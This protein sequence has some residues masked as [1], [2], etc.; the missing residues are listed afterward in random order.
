MTNTTELKKLAEAASLTGAQLVGMSA[1][2]F[3]EAQRL[4]Q[5]FRQIRPE[6]ILKLLAINADLV[7]EIKNAKGMI[8]AMKEVIDKDDARWKFL[9]TTHQDDQGFEWCVMRVKWDNGQI[10]EALHTYANLSD[11]DA[12]IARQAALAKAE[13][14]E[15]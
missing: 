1:P 11:M 14:G 6:A 10:S 12:E 2:E 9:H 3:A 4:K 15:L 7:E 13:G 5:Q 8:Q